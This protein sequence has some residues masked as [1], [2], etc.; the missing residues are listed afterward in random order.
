VP[1]EARTAARSLYWRGWSL[2]QISDEL[3]LAYSTVKSWQSRLGWDKAPS[4]VRMGDALEARWA[5]L[6]AK[7]D[8]T[9]K[10][11]KEIDL[12][13]RQ[14]ERIAR[15][16]KYAASGKEADLNPNIEARQSPEAR[17]K[18]A[19]TKAAKGRNYLTDEQWA[20][21]EADFHEWC[22]AHQKRWWSVRHQRTRKIK[23]S[24]QLGATAYFAREA[25]L[26]GRESSL[27]GEP[28]NQIFLSASKRQA[29]KF[30][31]FIVAWVRRVT[32]VSLTGGLQ[33]APMTIDM[34]EG[35]EPVEYHFLSTSKATAQGE[36]GDFYFDEFFWVPGFKELKRVASAMATHTIYKRTYFSSAST[37]THEAYPFWNGDE[38]NEGKRPEDRRDFDV[39][40]A[41][42]AEGAIMPDGSWQQIVTIQQAI[43]GGMGEFLNED[44][45]RQEYSED[46]FRNLFECEEI[47]D[48]LSSFPHSLLGPC[49]VDSFYAWPDY[50]SAEPRPFGHKGVSL[51][52]DP[53]KGGRDGAAVAVIA[54]PEKPGGKFRLLEKVALK[55]LDFEGQNR[56][57]RRLSRKYKVDDIA[58]DTTGAGAAV[59]ELVLGWFP[60]ARRIDYSV[61][62]KTAMVMKAQNVFR[63]KRFEYDAGWHDVTSAF[64]AIHP[65]LTA[66]GKQVT[67]VS[68]RS[69]AHGHANIAWAV[70]HCLINEPMDAS[71]AGQ[72]Q[73]SVE[74]FQ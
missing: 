56:E 48:T 25:F 70:M 18:R 41:A 20:A 54:W 71:E 59:L 46:E 28:R 19:A 30:R 11:F 73:A 42:L 23:K 10:D 53:D 45:L 69:S 6:I 38:W 8:K 67:Y 26:K 2:Q 5:A 63:N 51:G 16:A 68:G 4:H 29:L 74:F 43:D 50:R 15:V 3:G 1:F 24:R 17:E 36:S 60:L 57:L 39:S 55:G 31:R 35:N 66:T 52:Y 49:Q 64:M 65:Q 14:I 72:R 40:K 37:V 12:L 33:D 62:V 7:E 44:E 22:K 9:G 61:S 58:I 27:E 32:G 21:L 34:G 13:G 47:D